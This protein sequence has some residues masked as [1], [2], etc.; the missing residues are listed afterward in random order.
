MKAINL[1]EGLDELSDLGISRTGNLIDS[2]AVWSPLDLL[3]R[4][5]ERSKQRY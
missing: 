3:E 2:S 4:E 1:D 5:T